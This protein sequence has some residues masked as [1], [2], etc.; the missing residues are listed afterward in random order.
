MPNAA[1]EQRARVH[2]AMRLDVLPSAR[3]IRQEIAG[4]GDVRNAFD[5][6]TY[7]KGSALL[8][9]VESFV[10]EGPFRDGVRAYLDA[11]RFGSATADDLVRALSASSGRDLAPI[12]RS[13]LEQTG[14]PVV[15]IAPDCPRGRRPGANVSVRAYQPLGLPATQRQWIKALT[16]AVAAVQAKGW[17]P[18]ILC[19]EAARAL[20]KSST[21]REI[22]DLVVLSVPEIVAEAKV[23]AVGEIRLEG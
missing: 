22:P 20:V 16:R 14:V 12:F 17:F 19:S 8:R 11:H 5:A 23:E 3:R 13:F 1:F 15:S 6:I 7:A 2:D 18:V 4:V 21:E 10:G 9:M